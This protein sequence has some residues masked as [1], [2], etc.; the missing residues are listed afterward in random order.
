MKKN[1]YRTTNVRLQCFLKI[2][3]I[4]KCIL[5]LVLVGSLQAFSKGY[6]QNRISISLKNVS[7]KKALKEIERKT[8]YRFVYNDD[9][10]SAIPETSVDVN[11]GS[12]NDAMDKLL[13][14]T[15]LTYRVTDNN[16]VVII[17][18]G[19]VVADVIITGRVVDDQG[20]PLP[21]AS[22]SVKGTTIGTQTDL[23]GK[24][25]LNITGKAN[26][27]L[28]IRFVG[29]KTQEIPVNG[30]TVFTIKLISESKQL[31]E[32]VAIGY[33]T[34]KRG[35]LSG[36]VTSVGAKDLK[37]NPSNSLAEVLEGKLA[38]VQVTV[39]QGAPGA[40]AEI[41]IRGR[42]SIT[43]SGSPLYIVDGVQ[44]ENALNVLSPQDIASIDV[45]K[46][47]ASTAIYGARGSNGVVL[48]TTKGGKNTNGKFSVSYNA[49]VG[50]QKLAKELSV[51]S[52]YEFVEYQYERFRLTGDSTSLDRF[53]RT[54]SNF[55]TIK[56]YLN[57]P[58]VDWQKTMFGRKALQQT[59]NLSISG[60]TEKTQ[61]NLSLTENSQEGILIGSDF[62]RK[63]LNFRLDQTV[64]DKL[65]VGF[66]ARYNNQ[67]INGAGTSDNGG[68][69]SNNLRQI[70]RYTPFLQPGKDIDEYDAFQT[71]TLNPGNG[72]ALVNPLALIPAIYRKNSSN[73][74]N[75]NGY[76]NYTLVKNLSFRSMLSYDVNNTQIKAY[77]DTITS[78]ARAYNTLPVLSLT[79]GQVITIN[80]SNVFTYSNPALFHTKGALTA[81]IGQETYQTNAKANYLELRYFPAGITPDQA[82]ANLNLAAA[83]AGTLQPAPTSSEVPV[84]NVSFFSRLS[85]TYDGKYIFSGTIRADG[86]SIFGPTKKWGYFPSGSFAWK[87]TDESFM[88]QQQ[89]FSELKLRL[90]YGEAGN[91][92]ITPFSYLQS[93]STGKPY[94]LNNA[95]V[96]GVGP[97]TQSGNVILGNPDLQ[98]ETLTSKNIGL[99]MGFLKGR[100]QGSVDIYDNVTSNLLI[101][102]KI[103]TNSGET[104][105][106]QNVGSTENKGI[107]LQVAAT[108]V[109][110]KK[111]TWNANFNI[112]FNK[113]TIKNLGQQQSFTANSGWFSS[114]NANADYLVK[115]G[116]EVGTMYGLVNDGYYKTSDFNTT[117]YSNPLYPFATTQ[118][119][120]KAGVATSLT[121]AQPGSQKFVDQNGDG[122]IDGNDYVVIGHA[123]PKFIGGLNQTFNYGDF[124]MSVTLNY[125]YG[126]NVFNDNKLEFTNGY[127]NGSNLLS[128]F[129]NRWHYANPTTGAR[130]QATVGT[131]VIGAAPDVL[132]AINPDPQYWYP[133]T[134]VEYN[135][136]QSFAV[137]SSSFIRLNTVTIGYSLP[138]TVA[139]K[140]KIANLRIYATGTNL[141]TITGYS[142]YD[143]EVSVRRSTPLT[144]GVDYSAYPKSRAY[145]IGLNVTF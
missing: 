139:S 120:L 77:D 133:G 119:T 145:F 144:P 127:S 35:D 131:T 94:Y 113:N 117:A 118:Y 114:N 123:A 25:K 140:L 64:S 79:T 110:T 116:E 80:N 108:V 22:V 30:K 39:S 141:A 99:D 56:N 45:L 47:A 36:S 34:V 93:L 5:I 63:V 135:N 115:V 40:D 103:P 7:L 42:N 23:D 107:E 58:A 60:G 67:V 2:L 78:N 54:G 92:R 142:G 17:P 138:K 19:V 10:L 102:N 15:Q 50:V 38:G 33:G 76:V 89:V 121:L 104:D 85:Y 53:T 55:D 37:D 48:I 143:P 52:P 91:N 129:N 66:N 82:F 12:L 128:I 126:G 73:V 132:N 62:D 31:N 86:S 46:D 68:A 16:L 69:G 43:Q 61:Y 14:N 81:L 75:L 41:N 18:K 57:V 13:T 101:S 44:V 24:F 29:F 26:A 97:V 84:H 87:I 27:I 122:K 74:L 1:V 125:S 105:Q 32:V 134:G 70:V 9:L 100:I 72:L 124:D 90:S 11:D 136:P 49:L 111:F 109:R 137:E 88:K 65:K 20:E 28:V 83:P 8:D 112:S 98:W 95:L 21:S 130:T 4:S 71:L 96:N 59:H 3:M 106:F 6:S 51:M